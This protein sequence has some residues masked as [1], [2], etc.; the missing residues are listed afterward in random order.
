MVRPD[1]FDRYRSTNFSIASNSPPPVADAIRTEIRKYSRDDCLAVTRRAR[2]EADFK[3]SA[4][5]LAIIYSEVIAEH[6]RAK[7]DMHAESLA[8]SDYLR[9]IVPLIKMTDET[10]GRSWSSTAR[11]DNLEEM[12]VRLLRLEEEVKKISGGV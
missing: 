3:K 8:M 1:T 7:Q 5:K 12:N 6:Q 9:W 2:T 11:A 4:E 10:L